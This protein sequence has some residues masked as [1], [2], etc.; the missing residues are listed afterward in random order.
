MAIV[1]LTIHSPEGTRQIPITGDRLTIGRGDIAHVRINDP[2]LSRLHSSICCEG[3]RVW[4]LDERSTNG[5]YVNG[6]LVSANGKSLADG[7]KIR[8]GDSTIVWVGINSEKTDTVAVKAKT[9]ARLPLAATV[10][11]VGAVLV[12][13]VALGARLITSYA[14]N[15]KQPVTSN[16][17]NQS[18]GYASSNRKEPSPSNNYNSNLSA[19]S[20]PV[21][22][23]APTQL[24]AA[25][26]KLYR[27]MSKAEQ[28]DFVIAESRRVSL[29]VG[30]RPCEFTEQALG[31]I[32]RDVDSYAGRV[33]NKS[34][35]VWGEDLNRMFERARRY[36]PLIIKSFKK[37]NVS[38]IV[39]L[40]IAMIESEFGQ[41]CYE[42][43][44]AA[45]GMFQFIPSTA[46]AYKIDPRDRCDPEKMAP[47]AARYMR[48][49]IA[50]FGGDATGIGLSIAGYNRNPDNV[51]RD[52][53]DV[54]N[55]ENKDISFWTLIA[56]ESKLDHWFQE[57]K[58]YV[59]KFFAA[60]IVGE[61]PQY[62]GLQMRA[63]STYE[64]SER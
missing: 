54:I 51:R 27:S 14:Q 18:S 4:I 37:E 48:E 49:R 63:L 12:G 61:N 2:G 43:S 22:P 60:A 46:R 6:E 36:S 5:S 44:A 30:T 35:R 9:A 62:F 33:G 34:T 25:P 56:N 28:M 11:L 26:N 10:M 59:P 1:T 19:A 39:G 23:P 32:K 57:N 31:M 29:M 21:N 20:E 7:D 40:Y 15:R 50:G 47:A 41:H 58:K 13:A 55:S 17:A 8:I 3:D 38:G 45:M 24:P 64:E 53:Q 52:L 42:N 16:E